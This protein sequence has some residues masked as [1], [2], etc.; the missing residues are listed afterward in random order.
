MFKILH[1]TPHLGGGVGRVLLNY[2]T[3]VSKDKCYTHSVR[4]LDFANRESEHV[5][6][7]V[8]F[9]LKGNMG[10]H[11][12]ELFSEVKAADIVVLHWWNHPLLYALM[13]REI[14]PESRVLIWS[15]ISG[16]HPPFGFTMPLLDYPDYFVFTTPISFG[17]EEAKKYKASGG[18]KLK[19]VW[20]TG[21]VEH[22]LQAKPKPHKGF[23]IGYIGTVDY[24][25][26]H[27]DFIQMSSMVNVPG[28]EFIVC[29]GPNE[30]I[31]SQEAK[32]ISPS[33]RFTFHGMI[34]D[35]RA[36]LEK[37][38]VF[39]YPLAPYHY[40]TCEQA[41]CESMAA[42][43]P[44]VV[45]GNLTELHMIKDGVTGLIAN[46]PREYA[47]AIRKLWRRPSLRRELAANARQDAV[48]RFS[49]KQMVFAWEELFEQALLSPKTRK[50]WKGKIAGHKVSPAQLF[51]E[52]V[53]AFGHCFKLSLDAFYSK[54]M[55]IAK[56]FATQ[57][58]S[59]SRLWLAQ[60]KG[61]PWH[62]SSF[63]PEDKCLAFWRDISA[64]LSN[65]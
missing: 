19:V 34:K 11:L 33:T 15:H 20:S 25:K 37:F 32:E 38:D 23:R 22:L 42:G 28:A 41:L 4:C 2:L 7:Q 61:T 12:P 45:M 50:A 17:T 30:L 54:D 27:P 31:V 39:G 14:L 24:C 13:V 64:E 8:G 46:S 36:Q 49:M 16:L 29:G 9:S 51:L 35:V 18:E 52:A 53:G 40:G 48:K 21:G 3:A 60:T 47:A 62:Y 26:M 63:Y 65:S 59:R 44:P 58:F 10:Q 43:V 6:A 55:E 57:G 56:K 1:I 5:S